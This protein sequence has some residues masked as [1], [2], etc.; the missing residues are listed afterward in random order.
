[1]AE[2]EQRVARQ[3]GKPLHVSVIYMA[4]LTLF[5]IQAF[6]NQ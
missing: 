4:G 3:K 6:Y 1:M 5:I 2:D